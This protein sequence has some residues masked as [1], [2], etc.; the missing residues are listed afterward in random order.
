[1]FIA[2]GISSIRGNLTDKTVER[3]GQ[4]GGSFSNCSKKTQE[5]R[6]HYTI[7]T[8]EVEKLVDDLMPE[9]LF[10]VIHERAFQAYPGFKIRPILSNCKSKKFKS[11]IESL[12]QILDRDRKVT[13]IRRPV[14]LKKVS[15]LET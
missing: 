2:D 14:P 1:M 6:N 4:L 7:D 15:R 9:N 12:C 5:S 11:Q 8:K 3:Y 10:A 13:Q